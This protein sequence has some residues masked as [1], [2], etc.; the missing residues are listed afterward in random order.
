MLLILLTWII[1]LLFFVSSGIALK[2]ILKLTSTGVYIPVFLGLFLQS[3]LLTLCAFFTSI[4][5]F[6]LVSNSCLLL[7]LLLWKKNEIKT[8]FKETFND[9]ASLSRISKLFLIALLLFSLAKSAQ[10][11]FIIDNES[12]YLQTI[13]W[14]NDYG[15]VK[16]LGNLHIFF[17]QTSPFHILQAGF[18][19]S[20]ITDRINDLNG[21]IFITTSLFFIVEFEKKHA[22]KK[23]IHWIGLVLVFNVLFF[24]FLSAP[25]PDLPIILLSQVLF[26]YYL[27]KELT[28]SNFLLLLILFLFLFFIKITSAPFGVLL[29]FLI[30]K[31]KKRAFYL[32]LFGGFISTILLFKNYFLTG[33]PIYPFHFFSC[34]VDWKIPSELLKFI[35]IAT[36]NAGYFKTN[37]IQNSTVFNKLSSWIQLDGINRFFNWG[38]LML[39]IVAPFTNKIRT[40]IKYKILYSLLVLHFLSLLVTS[41]QFRFFLPEFIFLFALIISAIIRFFNLSFRQIKTLILA[42]LLLPISIIFFIDYSNFTNNKLHQKKEKYHWS[43]VLIPEKNTQYPNLIFEKIQEGNLEYY[44]PRENFFFYGNANGSLPCVNKVQLEYFKKKYFILPQ[45]RTKSIKDGFYSKRLPKND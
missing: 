16:G 34:E 45:Q 41:P 30:V 5:S 9:L 14:I 11:P 17:A 15:I 27:E 3:I 24:Q 22:E 1:L 19:F 39:F 23:E 25:S 36:E 44:S 28:D 20:I 43:Q 4:G 33:Y 18:N 37:S 42:S 26:Y 21:F 31:S 32:L 6:I 38:I 7:L 8:S 35:S 13:K 2:S 29:L 40:Q 12:Y 10:Y